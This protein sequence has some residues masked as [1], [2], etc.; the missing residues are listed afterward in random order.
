METNT[1][2]KFDQLA[3][4]FYDTL[5]WGLDKVQQGGEWASGAIP[6]L[7]G[8]VGKLLTDLAH[9]YVLYYAIISWIWV[10]VSFI[11][12][13]IV[14]HVVKPIGKRKM[15]EEEIFSRLIPSLIFSV[16]CLICF[17]AHIGDAIKT[18]FAPKVFIAEKVVEIIQRR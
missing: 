15:A 11:G 6:N 7:G 2:S 13:G 9:E 10:A 5:S 14:Y 1:V 3:D 4:K 18:T 16:I 17:C 8:D 12:A